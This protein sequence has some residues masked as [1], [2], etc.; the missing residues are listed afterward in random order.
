MCSIYV[1]PCAPICTSTVT[2]AEEDAR[3]RPRTFSKS[4][5]AAGHM[6][7]HQH[8]H[9]L[10]HRSSSSSTST[11]ASWSHVYSLT[12][13]SS[14]PFVSH[15]RHYLCDHHGPPPQTSIVQL[16][17]PPWLH[18]SERLSIIVNGWHCQHP[19]PEFRNYNFISAL[20]WSTNWY[21]EHY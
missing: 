6:C 18:T 7:I 16:A 9:R 13:S 8:H 14:L 2:P 4:P 20:G 21:I 19:P 3:P 10:H 17:D 1:P 5:L 12:S 15:D 11:K